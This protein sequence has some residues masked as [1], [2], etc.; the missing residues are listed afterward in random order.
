M[1]ETGQMWEEWRSANE[2]SAPGTQNSAPKLGSTF[3]LT[4]RVYTL[5]ELDALLQKCGFEIVNAFGNFRGSELTYKSA[6]MLV[7]S[8]KA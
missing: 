7:Q 1:A 3:V 5:T 2:K 4:Y 6:L 8:V